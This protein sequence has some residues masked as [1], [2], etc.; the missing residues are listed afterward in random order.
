M[1]QDD[2]A[3]IKEANQKVRNFLIQVPASYMPLAQS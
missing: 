2:N 3:G 1:A